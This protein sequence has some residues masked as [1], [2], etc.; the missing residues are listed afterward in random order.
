[1]PAT[2]DRGTVDHLRSAVRE[3]EAALDRLLVRLGRPLFIANSSHPRFRFGTPTAI[4]FLY[5]RAVLVVS[6]LNAMLHLLERGFAHEIAVL[7]RTVNDFLG[8]MISTEE[9]I[10]TGQPTAGQRRLVEQ[11]FGEHDGDDVA[12][13][14]PR[15][16]GFVPKRQIRAAEAR[17]VAADGDTTSWQERLA[18]LDGGLSGYVHGHYAQTME[19]YEGS[20]P[21]GHDG[22]RLGG[23]SAPERFDSSQGQIALQVVAAL[24]EVIRLA[25]HLRDE[26]VADRLETVRA[27]LMAS[28][29]Y[30]RLGPTGDDAH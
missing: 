27:H 17:A 9:A 3:L 20:T 28:P 7:A 22:F 19:L 11:F 14:A 23:M 12:S 21:G 30:G 4:H 13:D 2:P 5:L 6:G 25:R 18:S 8:E 16:G 29:M 10:R 1:M 15:Q 24:N 26:G